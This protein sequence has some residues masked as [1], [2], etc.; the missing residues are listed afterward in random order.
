MRW[1][2][3]ESGGL[4]GGATAACTRPPRRCSSGPAPG[5]S[6]QRSSARCTRCAAAHEQ[7]RPP[8]PPPAARP[9]P[10]AQD[11][12]VRVVVVE[13]AVQLVLKL[14]VDA[15]GDLASAVG[16]V[17]RGGGDV[18]WARGRGADGVSCGAQRGQAPPK[19]APATTARTSLSSS[20]LSTIMSR[21]ISMRS[22]QGLMRA[23]STSPC[24]R[25][26]RAGVGGQRGARQQRQAKASAEPTA[27]RSPAAP[28]APAPP[29]RTLH[30]CGPPPD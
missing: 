16:G 12:L 8:R 26:G 30:P 17:E 20:F 9:A 14:G 11:E 13:Q 23:T 29:P 7:H 19:A 2:R 10:D 22:S 15:L 24:A 5:V 18:L 21:A 25:G 4:R 3:Q 6:H 1:A 27:R 28:S